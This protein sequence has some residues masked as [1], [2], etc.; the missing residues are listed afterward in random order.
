MSR[1]EA[2]AKFGEH[3]RGVIV[4][5]G[6]KNFS[7]NFKHTPHPAELA[8]MTTKT[9]LTSFS[10]YPPSYPASRQASMRNKGRRLEVRDCLLSV[11]KFKSF[12]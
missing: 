1:Y 4:D 12:L 10:Y 3:E 5:R 11:N 6:A 9:T 7:K 8:Q 2:Y